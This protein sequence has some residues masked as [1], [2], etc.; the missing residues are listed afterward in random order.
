MDAAWVSIDEIY[1]IS[2]S[3]PNP[4][5]NRR[6][7]ETWLSLA[8]AV[9]LLSPPQRR[10]RWSP[11]EKLKALASPLFVGADL[12]WAGIGRR[13]WPHFLGQRAKLC[14]LLIT[15]DKQETCQSDNNIKTFWAAGRRTP[16]VTLLLSWYW[17]GTEKM[18]DLSDWPAWVFVRGGF[19]AGVETREEAWAPLHRALQWRLSCQHGRLK[20][21][22][23]R[24]RNRDK[25]WK[26]Y[27]FKHYRRSSLYIEVNV[28]YD[29]SSCPHRLW[30]NYFQTQLWCK[31]WRQNLFFVPSCIQNTAAAM[32]WLHPS[33]SSIVKSFF[34]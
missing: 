30:A 15:E 8:V 25:W 21:T 9:L 29:H 31:R 7:K 32:M 6:E 23:Y 2:L 5:Q 12:R 27:L 4:F 11:W 14:R 22:S 19:C 28:R 34:L 1:W 33:K 16:L 3:V 20:I 24:M 17:A 10:R 26:K 18:F 13:L